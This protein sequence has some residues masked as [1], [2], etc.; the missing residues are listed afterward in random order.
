MANAIVTVTIMPESPEIDLEKVL[1]EAKKVIAEAAGEGETRS[2]IQPVA[3]GI[4]ALKIIFVI[5]EKKGS[6]DP[7]AEKI[8]ALEG[9]NSAEISD[10]RRAIG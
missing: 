6:P 3:F 8:Q 5:D 2:S 10:V 4:K 7:I 9:V 1:V